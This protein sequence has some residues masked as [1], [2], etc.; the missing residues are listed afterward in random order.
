MLLAIDNSGREGYNK[1]IIK[2]LISNGANVNTEDHR[3]ETPLYWGLRLGNKELAERLISNGANINIE[4]NSGKTPLYWVIEGGNKEVVELLILK[5]AKLNVKDGHGKTPLHW[6]FEK[7]HKDIC[8]LLILKG[9]N[10]N[11]KDNDGRAPLHWAAYNGY[12]EIVEI[13]ISK[14]A[15]VNAGDNSGNTPLN[16]AYEKNHQNVADLLISKGATKKEGC[17]ITSA[18]CL[19][20]Q[21]PDNCY[22]LKTF[23]DFRDN[24]LSKQPDGDKL[25]TEYYTIAPAIVDYINKMPYKD[26]IYK[27]IWTDYLS[28]CLLLIEEGQNE[29][30]KKIYI[31][32]VYTLSG[33]ARHYVG[34]MDGA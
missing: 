18:T 33:Y 16:R 24:W 14:G 30:A 6:A 26:E 32:M 4:D 15:D 23:R 9:A 19:S 3:G 11:I 27:S 22:E 29:E 31:N 21:K 8:K 34:S 12:K 28:N 17:F 20:L 7:G 1:E 5:G 10:V 2:I 13:L 25:I